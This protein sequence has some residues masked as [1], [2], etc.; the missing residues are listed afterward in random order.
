MPDFV[1]TVLEDMASTT[2]FFLSGF[3]STYWPWMLGILAILAIGGMIFR[4]GRG[5]IRR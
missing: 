5:A 2:T 4:F 3:I 1:G